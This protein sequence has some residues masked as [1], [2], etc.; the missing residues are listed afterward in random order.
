LIVDDS[1]LWL[2]VLHLFGVTLFLG[3]II[4]TAWWK[5]MADRTRNAQVI[6][7][8]QRQVALTD[9]VFTGCGATILLAAGWGNAAMH[10]MHVIHTYWLAW[11]LYLFSATGFIWAGILIPI[12][13]RQSRMARQFAEGGNIPPAYWRLGRRWAFWGFIATV[14]PLVNYYWMV[15]K[16]N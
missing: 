15:F 14:L 13:V 8:A 16:P 12:Q 11:G 2:K 7:F 4:V 9:Y 1:Y 6:A 10:G 3:N 5:L